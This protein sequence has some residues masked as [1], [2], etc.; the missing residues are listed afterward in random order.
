M[1]Y[2]FYQIYGYQ[3]LFTFSLLSENRNFDFWGAPKNFVKSQKA[4][5][6][7]EADFEQ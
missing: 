6:V 4:Q 2:D 7:D 5:V 1:F 3:I